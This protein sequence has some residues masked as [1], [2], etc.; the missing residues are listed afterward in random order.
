MSTRILA[1]LLAVVLVV[2]IGLGY[3]W[4]ESYTA[5]RLTQ[6]ELA[7]TSEA[8][9]VALENAQADNQ[10]LAEALA[11]EKERNDS[12]ENQI[13]DIS[14]TVGKLD[15]LSKTDPELL[16]KY[17]KVYFL[18]ENY[19]PRDLL[20]IPS[21][22]V[23][24][25]KDEYIVRQVWPM[26]QNL[27]DSAKEDGVT[28]QITSAYRSFAAQASLKSSYTFTYGS[29][30]NKFSADQGYS[31]HQL[32]TAIDFTSPEIQGRLTGFD[33]TKAYEWL[34]K[35]AYRYGFIISYPKNNS[36]YQYEPWHWRYVGRDL[37]RFIRQENTY[38]YKL[39]QR[40]LDT[41][42]VSLFD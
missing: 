28:I 33:K 38:F 15:K 34:A 13:N 17:S 5:F 2:S 18:S 8:A 41:Y 10:Q 21:I 30:A 39:D 4:Y 24:D 19:V 14:G 23:S 1:L 22:Y 35:N 25:G 31:E 11:Q 12:F 9:R 29:G 26:L 6:G 42:L 37:A 16:K 20:Q 32:G 40:T 7:S 27:L 3:K 36:Y